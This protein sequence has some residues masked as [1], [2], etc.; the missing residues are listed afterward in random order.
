MYSFII[1]VKEAQLL[2]V[3]LGQVVLQEQDSGANGLWLKRNYTVK[4]S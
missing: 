1:L 3:L 2:N 4:G